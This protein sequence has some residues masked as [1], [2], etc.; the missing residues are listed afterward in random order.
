MAAEIA[1]GRKNDNHTEET[2][3]SAIQETLLKPQ[4]TSLL[5]EP[6]HPFFVEKLFDRAMARAREA[7]NFRP[8]IS[9]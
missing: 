8:T 7:L 1:E 3:N 2:M 5:I 4:R 6:R 9:I